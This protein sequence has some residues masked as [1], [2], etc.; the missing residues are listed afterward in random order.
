MFL[1]E[2]D[3]SN[4][5]MNDKNSHN[6]KPINLP[7]VVEGNF[8]TSKLIYYFSTRKESQKFCWKSNVMSKY[9]CNFLKK[10]H[11]FLLMNPKFVIFLHYIYF[12]TS[13]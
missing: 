13:G 9:E 11:L 1:L 5:D 6:L 8:N 12:S 3:N 10:N 2:N 4:L 7:N